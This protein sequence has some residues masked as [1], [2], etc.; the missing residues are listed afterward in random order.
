MII[1]LIQ[2]TTVEF[3]VDCPSPLVKAP[4]KRSNSCAVRRTDDP[5]LSPRITQVYK[6]DTFKIQHC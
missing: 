2:Q 5:P 3:Q 6:V 4:L 1:L